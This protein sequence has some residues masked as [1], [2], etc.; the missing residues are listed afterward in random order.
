[1]LVVAAHSDYEA[2]ALDELAR[3]GFE[4]RSTL[5]TT[6]DELAAVLEGA[7]V[8]DAWDIVLVIDTPDGPPAARSLDALA[9]RVGETPVIAIGRGAAAV[10]APVDLVSLR[11][12]ELR[13]LAGAAADALREMERHRERRRGAQA[14]RASEVRFSTVFDSAPIG[15][16]LVRPDGRFLGVNP[17]FSAI[18]RRDRDAIVAATAQEIA[19]DD[20]LS[21]V[22]AAA[23]TAATAGVAADGGLPPPVER[24]AV[25][26]D[27]TPVWVSV[28]AAPALEE[29]GDVAYLVVHVEDVTARREAEAA[30]AR[31]DALLSALFDSTNVGMC[32]VD[33]Q[34]RF[35]A[36][37][38]AYQEILGYTGEEL[39]Q[40][41]FH[42]V[43]HP[44]ELQQ[45]V[46]LRSRR[47]AEGAGYRMEKRYVRKDG[48]V[49]WT[50]L[51]G[52]PLELPGEEP[53]AIGAIV[54]ITARKR[55]EGELEQ[56]ARLLGSMREVGGIGSW[57][58][59]RTAPDAEPQLTWSDEVFAIL[60]LEPVTQPRLDD[61]YAVVHPDDHVA[62][63]AQTT[64]AI[65]GEG[66]VDIEVRVL[67]DGGQERRVR[68][69]AD[70]LDWPDGG[71]RLAGVLLDVTPSV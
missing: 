40:L 52:A 54:D 71:S 46:S 33:A 61:L 43:S 3:G 1:M 37:N 55:A 47:L 39:A 67:R 48:S 28:G 45:N 26:A 32:I 53:L 24:R 23:L 29:R 59:V 58:A 42:D 41:R 60:G 4:H 35:K 11:C 66:R 18:A 62:L 27:G 15:L 70:H 49:V 68:V 6:P 16:A 56:N 22:R 20:L 12:V 69:L 63:R 44:D 14:L 57:V 34:G 9:A 36:T 64:A 17:V 19:D 10:D 31:S 50:E 5:V 65:A 8:Q 2:L 25:R 13:S 7:G 21:C 51:S 38:R 30:Q